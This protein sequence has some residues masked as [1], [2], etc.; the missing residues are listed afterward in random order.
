MVDVTDLLDIPYAARG[1]DPATGVD[2]AYAVRRFLERR[3]PDFD[4]HEL[5]LDPEEETAAIAAAREGRSRWSRIGT[6]IFA[7]TQSGDV[8]LSE[9]AGVIGISALVDS[10]RREVITA[11]PQFGVHLLPIRR[12]VG[13]TDVLRRLA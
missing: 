5:P 2:C 4:P 9:H 6:S 12:I 7:A 3:F 10:A 11:T 8:I 13:V 1:T